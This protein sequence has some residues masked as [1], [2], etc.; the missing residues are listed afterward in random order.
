MADVEDIGI[1]PAMRGG[2]IREATLEDAPV[3]HRLICELEQQDFP[4]GAFCER[5]RGQMGD[6]RHTCLVLEADGAVAGMLNMRIE[7]QLHHERPT[8]E[9]LECVV[10]PHVRGR[11]VGARLLARAREIARAADCELIEL[12]SRLT[13]VDAHRFYEREGMAKTHAHL[14]MPL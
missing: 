1:A 2:E 3:I 14:T 4:Y 7:P 5:L 13:R 6:G 10:D 12:T 8:A 9:V 11:R